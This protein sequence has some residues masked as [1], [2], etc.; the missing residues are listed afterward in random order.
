MPTT[1]TKSNTQIN[2]L[3]LIDE[4]TRELCRLRAEV[5]TQRMGLLPR[6]VPP[7]EVATPA[8][9][10]LVTNYLREHPASTRAQIADGLRLHPRTVSRCLAALRHNAEACYVGNKRAARWLLTSTVRTPITR[11][12]NVGQYGTRHPFRYH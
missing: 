10:T 7:A 5:A 1:Q 2:T 11:K 8:T 12:S 3:Y 4:L 6:D 9:T